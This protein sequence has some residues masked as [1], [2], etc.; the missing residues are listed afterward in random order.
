MKVYWI[1][2]VC[3]SQKTPPRRVDRMAVAHRRLGQAEGAASGRLDSFSQLCNPV[4]CDKL[5]AHRAGSFLRPAG[6]R[7]HTS[8]RP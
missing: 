4:G 7:R 6:E 3:E 1:T 5:A 8:I 2:A